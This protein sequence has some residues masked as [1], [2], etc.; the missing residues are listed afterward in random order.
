MTKAELNRD[1]KRLRNR[2]KVLKVDVESN[3]ITQAEYFKTIE[4]EIKPEFRRLYYADDTFEYMNRESILSMLRM[5]L[6][7]RFI[8]THIFGIKIEL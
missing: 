4:E 7:H 2:V 8:A 6:S 3:R 1:I 5:N